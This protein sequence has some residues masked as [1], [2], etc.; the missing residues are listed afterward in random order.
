VAL[1]EVIEE[2][3]LERCESRLAWLHSQ[4]VVVGW[5]GDYHAGSEGVCTYLE[6]KLRMCNMVKFTATPRGKE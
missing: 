5:V 6:T 1:R 4:A 2:G 3:G